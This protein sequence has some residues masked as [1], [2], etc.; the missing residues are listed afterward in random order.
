MTCTV[1]NRFWTHDRATVCLWWTF[2][3]NI[4]QTWVRSRSCGCLVTWFCYQMIAKPGNKTAAHSW[5]D[6]YNEAWLCFF[7]KIKYRTS[8]TCTHLTSSHRVCSTSHGHHGQQARTSSNVQDVGLL[9]TFMHDVDSI[10]QGCVVHLVLKG[11]IKHL[12]PLIAKLMGPTWGPSGADR[13]QVGPM[14]ALWTLL[15]GML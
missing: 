5:P 1:S 15:S 11:N 6:P 12:S 14:L 13:T 8:P 4:I 7:W 9:A 3:T 10:T 2:W